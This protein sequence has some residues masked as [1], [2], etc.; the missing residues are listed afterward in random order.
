MGPHVCPW[1]GGY[2]IDNRL[3]RLIH[4][5]EAILRPYVRAGMKVMDVGCGMGLFSI[6]LAELV[7]PSGQVIAVDLQQQMLDVLGKRAARVGVADRIQR[8]RCEAT[9]IGVTEPIGFALSFYS[10]HEVPD[11]R[12]LLQEIHENLQAAGQLLVVEPK[13]HVPAGQFARMV[14]LAAEIGFVELARPTV[15]WSRAILLGKS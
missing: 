5:P 15:R 11:L 7:G 13:G 10:A 8:H 12:H 6:A 3:R 2:F 4:N 9:S 14:S 1:W